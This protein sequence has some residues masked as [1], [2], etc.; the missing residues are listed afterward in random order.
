[1]LGGYLL[2][3]YQA[4]IP[5]FQTLA[6]VTWFGW[7][8]GHQ[9]LIGQFDWA[10]L[11]LCAIVAVILFAVG[12]ELFARRDLGVDQPHPMAVVPGGDARPRRS[13]EPVAR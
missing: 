10:S 9:P 11:A 6:N 4:A 1:M 12:I 3:G 5:A 7:T 2:N 13:H 8:V